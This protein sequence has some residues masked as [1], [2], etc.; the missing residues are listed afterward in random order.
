MAGFQLDSH[1]ATRDLSISLTLERAASAKAL[2][3]A[4]EHSTPLLFNI[5][6]TGVILAM[7]E[8]VK[9]AMNE[10]VKEIPEEML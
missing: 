8:K 2:A 1:N 6:G 10:P 4:T 9:S 7:I 5:P 3:T